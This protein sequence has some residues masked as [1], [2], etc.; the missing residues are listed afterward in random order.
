[1][2]LPRLRELSLHRN[3]ITTIGSLTGCPRLSKLWL[4]QN[5]ITDLS[6][7]YSNLPEL[8]ELWLQGN[9]IS[10]LSGFQTFPR[11]SK[12]ALAGNPIRD[13]QEVQCLSS[14]IFLKDVSFNDFHFGRC[15][16]ADD[17]TQY[18]SFIFLHLK[19]VQVLDGVKLLGEHIQKA[20]ELYYSEMKTFYD[21]IQEIEDDYLKNLREIES[22]HQVK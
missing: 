20:E 14:L 6:S 1:L 19:Q 3:Q 2:F 13:Y 9:Q 17:T 15:P 7:L 10:S 4:F 8:E 5:Q 22:D 18:K 12:L 21:S 16:I 11:L